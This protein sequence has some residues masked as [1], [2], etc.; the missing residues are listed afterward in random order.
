[1]DLLYVGMKNYLSYKSEEVDLSKHKGLHLVIGR[2]DETVDE[3]EGNGAGKTAF[4]SATLFAH[5][6]RCR[7]QM[8]KD[9]VNE[10]VV[11]IDENGERAKKAEVEVHSKHAGEYYKVK[12]SVTAKGGQTVTLHGSSTYPTKKWNDLTLK[13]GVSK[14]TGKRESGISRTEQRIADIFG[15]DVDLFINSVYFEQSNIDTF[16]KGSLDEKDSVIR[17]AVGLNRWMDYAKE[18]SVDLS[19]VEKNI[20]RVKA[21]LDEYCDLDYIKETIVVNEKGVKQLKSDIDTDKEKIEN[22]KKEIEALI[23]RLAIEENT[24]DNTKELTKK[25]EHL[26]IKV[27]KIEDRVAGYDRMVKGAE[28][29]IEDVGVEELRKNDD[30]VKAKRQRD[31]YESQLTDATPEQLEECSTLLEEITNKITTIDT[32]MAGITKQAGQVDKAECPLGIND[33]DKLGEESKCNIKEDLRKQWKKHDFNKGKLIKRKVAGHAKIKEMTESIAAKEKFR[34]ACKDVKNIEEVLGHVDSRIQGYKTSIKESKASQVELVT[35]SST[36]NMELDEA[37]RALSE[38]VDSKADELNNLLIV[39]RSKLKDME[40]RV[41]G[42]EFKVREAEQEIKNAKAALEKTKDLR[43][44]FNKDQD[45][46]NLIK[47][48]QNVVKKE[49]PHLLV[50]NAI[51]EIKKHARRFIYKLSNGRLDIDFK[52][53]RELKSSDNKANAFD[54][55]INVDGKW[56]KYAQTSGGQRARADVAIHLAYVCFMANMS[57]SRI[58]TI[59]LDEVG[60]ALDKSGV[61]NFIDIV[62]ELIEEYD[63]KKVFNITQNVEMKKMIDNRILVT[64]TDDGSKIKIQ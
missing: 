44:E 58:E 17:S 40:G 35:E 62:K 7:G 5:Y 3:S 8:D 9:L 57:K 53:E 20:V 30:L 36:V 26:K 49:I 14:R 33:C 6:G 38:C 59:F 13:A 56:L 64:L 22:Y 15:A 55:F 16:A 24:A 10:D 45:R 50:A 18:M 27:R 48:A 23:K 47:E 31:E 11:R 25:V 51:P 12:R 61:E 52:L 39:E 63:F 41:D 37:K 43:D 21:L 54:I 60:A 28:T 34:N 1:M 29:S 32:Q 46:K 2:N 42:A 19:V 4:V